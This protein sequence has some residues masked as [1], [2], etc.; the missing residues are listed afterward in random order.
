M[1]TPCNIL[2]GETSI[3]V[4]I[5]NRGQLVTGKSGFSEASSVVLVASNT[6]LNLWEPLSKHNFIITEIIIRGD[7]NINNTVDAI[8]TIYECSEGPDSLT[9]TK[10][11]LPQP[12]PRSGLLV[13]SGLNLE[14]TEGRWVNAVASDTNIYVT[15]MGYY[16]CACK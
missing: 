13:L 4:K 5:T 15:V 3:P 10:A 1:P 7:K 8:V 12:I 11:I 14:V 16:I 9:Q 2:D 6:P